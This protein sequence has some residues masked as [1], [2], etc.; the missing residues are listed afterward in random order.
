M[1]AA[2]AA[3]TLAM[4][5]EILAQTKAS[6]QAA[7]GQH[8]D[9]WKPFGVKLADKLDSLNKAGQLPNA[10]EYAVAWREIA[11]GLNAVP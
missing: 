5:A 11:V 3:G 4:P 2:I 9:A 8:V 7:L 6:N 1:A 10:A